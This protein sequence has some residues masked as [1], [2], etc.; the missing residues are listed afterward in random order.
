M[1]RIT[2]I[3]ARRED[4]DETYYEPAAPRIAM[5]RLRAKGWRLTT[6]RVDAGAEA[7]R[8]RA[9]ADGMSRTA[10]ATRDSSSV[11]HAYDIGASLAEQAANEVEAAARGRGS[12]VRS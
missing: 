5:K 4:D 1:T 8:L 2:V 10:S 7:A 12:L 11:T 9:H 3:T 6:R